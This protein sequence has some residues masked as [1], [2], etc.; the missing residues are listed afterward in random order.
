MDSP[1]TYAEWAD[2]FD[3]LETH[4]E[5][6]PEILEALQQGTLSWQSGV[7]ERFISRLSQVLTARMDR[8]ADD[9][10]K[11]LR[12]PGG[13]EASLVQALLR[14]RR[15]FLNV[16]RHQKGLDLLPIQRNRRREKEQAYDHLAEVVK[17]ALDMKQLAAIMDEAAEKAASAEAGSAAAPEAD[18]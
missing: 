15:Q 12:A 2:A 9:F 5:S 16:L 14:F 11:S 17:Q 13:G 6:D 10:Q 1:H 7:A 4:P 18:A 8:A 3:E